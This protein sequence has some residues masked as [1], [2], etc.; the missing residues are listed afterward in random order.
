M[1][2]RIEID[3]SPGTRTRPAKGPLRRAVSGAEAGSACMIG[4]QPEQVIP[5]SVTAV[6][7]G[8]A[9]PVIPWFSGPRTAGDRGRSTIDSRVTTSQVKHPNY[10]KDPDRGQT[11]TGHQE[12][13]RQLRRQ[14]L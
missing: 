1:R 5:A 7:H 8:P 14:V 6:Y 9:R 10:A 13:L 2:A 11:R 3:L 4:V 12:A